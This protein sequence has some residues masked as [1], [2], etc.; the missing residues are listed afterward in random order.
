DLYGRVL[1]TA[2]FVDDELDRLPGL[3]DTMM[4]HVRVAPPTTSVYPG[5]IPWALVHTIDDDDQGVAARAELA[6]AVARL[7]LEAFDLWSE[8]IEAVA[9]GRDG[10]T[11][12][13]SARFTVAYDVVSRD[14]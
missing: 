9:M 2:A 6:E 1:L 11:A 7:G 14:P 4:E 5:R 10:E 8:L 12:A 13:A 3:L